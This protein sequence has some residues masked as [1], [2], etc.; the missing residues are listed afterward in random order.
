MPRLSAGCEAIRRVMQRG[1]RP[2]VVR[3]YDELDTLIALRSPRGEKREAPESEAES[4]AATAR[5]LDLVAGDRRRAARGIQRRLLGS[6][7]SATGVLNRA[8]DALLPRLGGGCLLIVGVEGRHGLADAEAIAA[9]REIE[10]AGGQDLGPGPGERW[11][12]HRYDVS[13]QLSK[14]FEAG[15]FADTMEVAVSWDRLLDLYRAVKA[16]VAREAFVMAHFSHAYTDGCSIYFT[17]AAAA[18]AEPKHAEE[19]YDRIWRSALAA[20]TGVGATISHHHGVGM[21]KAAFMPDEHGR[22]MAIYR[23]LKR[24]LDPRGI[25]NPGKMGLTE[26]AGA[27]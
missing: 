22:S 26:T 13:F 27:A 4:E 1:L 3:L 6:A 18:G 15:A 25:L 8:V 16:A 14:M 19:R 5:L 10:G 20:A 11:Y 7:L 17:F 21:S 24:Q 23:A 12:K 9:W 2:A